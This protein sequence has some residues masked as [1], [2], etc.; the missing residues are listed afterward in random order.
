[1]HSG[2]PGSACSLVAQEA[3][4]IDSPMDEVLGTLL[5]AHCLT[6]GALVMLA[7]S[8]QESYEFQA[9]KREEREESRRDPS[10]RGTSLS[11]RLR[12]ESRRDAS[13]R[14][15][16]DERS[17]SRRALSRAGSSLTLSGGTF[18]FRPFW[19]LPGTPRTKKEPPYKRDP[20]ELLGSRE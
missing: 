3:L 9:Y 1:M 8:V 16:P 7:F 20:S 4:A 10:R 11:R 6:G 5:L 18:S 14:G 12:E 13:R 19:G 17:F 15:G 2:A